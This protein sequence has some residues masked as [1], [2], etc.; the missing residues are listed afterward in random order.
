[1]MFG[2]AFEEAAVALAVKKR[3]LFSEQYKIYEGLVG[4]I[5]T[6]SIESIFSDSN[7]V[8]IYPEVSKSVK[9]VIVDSIVELQIYNVIASEDLVYFCISP[10]FEKDGYLVSLGLEY[11]KKGQ[12][13]EEY[14]CESVLEQPYQNEDGCIYEH[15][16]GMWYLSRFT[17]SG[18]IYIDEGRFSEPM[19]WDEGF[20]P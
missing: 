3:D 1:M 7:G 6:H 16:G 10:N 5:E 19:P 18:P 2:D 9:D 12:P 8:T 11:Y 20:E 17:A 4:L 13:N 14:I 15:L